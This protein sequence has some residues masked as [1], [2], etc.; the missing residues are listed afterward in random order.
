MILIMAQ[1]V[2]LIGAGVSSVDI[3][4]EISPFATQIYQASRSGDFDLP[5]TALPDNA[6]R[7]SHVKSFEILESARVADDGGQKL[8]VSVQL[9][10][11]DRIYDLDYVVLCTGYSFSLPFLPQLH[12]DVRSFQEADETVLVTREGRQIHNLH[13]G[14]FDL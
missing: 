9:D 10:S 2:L 7:V 4:K 1:K 8:P 13:K 12:D 14:E 11:G 6:S 5:V 3:A